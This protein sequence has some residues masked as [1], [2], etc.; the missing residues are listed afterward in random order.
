MRIDR[1]IFL[2]LTSTQR[3]LPTVGR[4]L[5]LS[6]TLTHFINIGVA[7][8]LGFFPFSG[9]KESFFGDLHGQSMD[10]VDSFMQKRWWWSAGRWNG[11]APFS[12]LQDI[13]P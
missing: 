13:S 12:L 10:A 11:A 8:S 6:A 2:R 3:Y 5:I 9:W 1:R 7:A 4:K